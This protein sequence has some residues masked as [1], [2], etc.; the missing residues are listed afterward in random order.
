MCN[1]TKQN[2][3]VKDTSTT[4]RLTLL[5]ATLHIAPIELHKTKQLPPASLPVAENHGRHTY[6]H[7]DLSFYVVQTFVFKRRPF[8]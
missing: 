7:F 4:T 3:S 5:N 2:Y 1:T 8:A 6:L